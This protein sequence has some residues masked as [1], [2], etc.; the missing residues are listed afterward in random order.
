M[1][2]II[3]ILKKKAVFIPLIVLVLIAGAWA[4]FGAGKKNDYQT[5]QVSKIDF[6]QEVSVTGEVVAASDVALGFESGGKVARIP[7]T[8]GSKVRAGQ[9]LASVSSGDLYAT[10][11]D[12]Q[13][14]LQAA[15]ARLAILERGTRAEELEITNT[16]YEQ[17]RASFIS[18]ISNSYIT[19]DDVLRDKIDPLFDNATGPNPTMIPFGEG[20]IEGELEDI[21]VEVGRMMDDWEKSI[22]RMETEGYDQAYVVEARN[23]LKT[24]QDFLNRLADATG[25][26][27]ESSNYTAT[28]AAS[29]ASN[30]ST[31]RS[32]INS[33]ISSL[34][35]AEQTFKRAEGDLKLDNA[36]ASSEDLEIELA[37][38]KSA[39]ASLMQAQVELGKT[40]IVAPFSGTVTKLDLKVGEIVSGNTPV[41]SM[42][43]DGN[44]QIESFIPEADIAKVK[45]GNTGTT[46]L[47]AYG[48]DVAFTAVV[49]SIDLAQTEVEGVA[50]YKTILQF[51]AADER[52]RSGMTANIDLI[53]GTRE[54]VLAI[55][56]SALINTKGIKTVL[57]M[58]DKGKTES[59]EI[60]TGSIDSQG[61][62][63]VADGL[64]EGDTIVTNPVKK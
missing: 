32:S 45:I 2:K 26:F 64:K 35:S 48:D 37:N 20:R 1:K 24:M 28:E 38:V 58:N 30:I 25:R 43:S 44:F 51:T 27:G 31:G 10:V 59:R 53:S 42:I 52:I 8:I 17:A 13:A 47:D 7:V 55:P 22:E 61:N 62:I 18:T 39:Q 63:E 40:S 46:T 15:R 34:N 56:Q 36:G 11:L 12:R 50:T 9:V 16:T 49:T 19:A 57:I 6:T 5:A 41:I 33:L 14:K 4:V 3:S 21:R 54:G 29:Y 23:N 60:K